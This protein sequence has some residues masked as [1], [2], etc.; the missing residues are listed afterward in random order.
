MIQSD[1]FDGVKGI[2]GIYDS[3]MEILTEKI[4]L[5]QQLRSLPELTPDQLDTFG[6]LAHSLKSGVCMM[7]LARL[8][9]TLYIIEL[10]GRHGPYQDAQSLYEIFDGVLPPVIDVSTIPQPHDT[11]HSLIVCRRQ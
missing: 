8:A 9:H 1:I 2:P 11:S 10:R 4:S 3:L 7:G 6:D 5:M